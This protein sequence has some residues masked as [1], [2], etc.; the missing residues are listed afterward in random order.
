MNS[1]VRHDFKIIGDN[2][3]GGGYYK[4]ARLV[5]NGTVNGDMDCVN[6]K[7]V[8]DSKVNGNLKAENLRVVG[9]ISI[10]GA[11]KSDT[12]VITG[13]MDTGGDVQSKKI[14]VKGGIT[15]EGSI[16]GNEMRLW[17]YINI[18]KNCEAETLKADG[19]LTIE[20]LLN[21]DKIDIKTYGQCRVT[22]IGGDKITI[23]KS[24]NSS[25]AHMI[26]FLFASSRHRNGT[27]VADLIEGNEIR[28]AHTQAKAVRGTN[29]VIEDGCNI[30]LV[31][32]KEN[33]RI[34]S[35]ASVKEKRKV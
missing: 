25:V 18:N 26:K 22:E 10:A 7:S 21:A 27:L 4:N 1:T 29:V 20:G 28:L 15:S 19:Q 34:H 30:D 23:R 12:T 24:S 33:L 32:Y 35:R 9:S 8:G 31:E 2:S 13:N 16:M 11:S 5:G 3:T 6:F 14:V 17:G